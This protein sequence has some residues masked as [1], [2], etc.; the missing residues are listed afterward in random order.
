MHAIH[1]TQWW[2]EITYPNSFGV[3]WTLAQGW[4]LVHIE[5]GWWTPWGLVWDKW[6][7][8]TQQSHGFDADSCKVFSN[9]LSMQNTIQA[10]NVEIVNALELKEL[11]QRY[12][13]VTY[14]IS[15]E[16]MR[17]IYFV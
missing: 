16:N 10:T 8:C 17:N 11:Q 2:S 1:T 6:R 5:R 7:I 12:G 13:I 4:T 9:C 15:K 14:E 3:E